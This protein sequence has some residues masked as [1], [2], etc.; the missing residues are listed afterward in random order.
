[1][2]TFQSTNYSPFES[3]L[4]GEPNDTILSAVSLFKDELQYYKSKYR[5]LK[6]NQNTT[7][8]TAFVGVVYIFS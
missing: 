1:M 7:D 5:Q 4:K 3:A 8:N 2:K 6:L